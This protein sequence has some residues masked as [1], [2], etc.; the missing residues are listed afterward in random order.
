MVGELATELKKADTKEETFN[1][2]GR[3]QR[4]DSPA[5][6]GTQS[7]TSVLGLSAHIGIPSLPGRAAA[8]QQQEADIPAHEG[9]SVAGQGK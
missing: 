4:G 1:E 3:E 7:L 8:Q 9:T 2:M 5:Y 6:P